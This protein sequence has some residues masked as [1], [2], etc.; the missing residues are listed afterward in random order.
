MLPSGQ[1][2]ERDISWL[3]LTFPVAFSAD[4]RTV[5]FTEENT[6]LGPM[7]STGV[8]GTDGSPAVRLGDGSAQDISPDGKWALAIVPS[9]PER[10]VLY[11]MGPGQTKTI[12]TG[13]VVAYENAAFF[14][15][16]KT[17][18]LCGHESGRG[19]RCYAQSISGGKPRP[20]TPEDRS[21]GPS[22]PTGGGSSRWV[23]RDSR[24]TPPT[25][26]PGLPCRDRG[27]TTYPSDGAPTASRCSPCGTGTCRSGSSAWTSRPAAAT[28]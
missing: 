4:G 24:S 25:A 26:E 13:P 27:R 23:P 28:S 18:L 19:V 15:D 9:K 22:P 3:D 5:L 11:P 2:R 1:T 20:V 10:V 21:V 14:P 12:E 16:G 17:L 7:Y 6:N 8:R